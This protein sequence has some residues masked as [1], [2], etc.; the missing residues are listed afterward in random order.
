MGQTLIMDIKKTHKLRSR[1]NRKNTRKWNN[2]STASYTFRLD[3]DS[4]GSAGSLAFF[5]GKVVVRDDDSR[6]YHEL[7][8]ANNQE[9]SV[10]VSV[11]STDGKIYFVVI[12]MPTHFTTNQTYS[13]K[14]KIE[15]HAT[16]PASVA[17]SNINRSRLSIKERVVQLDLLKSDHIHLTLYDLSGRNV[18]TLAKGNFAKGTHLFPLQFID[19]GSR[20]VYVISLTGNFQ[21]VH[22]II[23]LDD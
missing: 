20:G 4:L 12:S 21:E 6:D 11:D 19:K 16:D 13:Y 22:E 5:Q 17:L 8:M 15:K 18:G 7:V 10:T 1:N 2:S 9:G 14:I 23:K 3:G